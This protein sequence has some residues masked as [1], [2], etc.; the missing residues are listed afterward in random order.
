MSTDI[1]VIAL[2]LRPFNKRSVTTGAGN[3][4]GTT[5]VDVT[6]VE[7]DNFWTDCWVLLRTGTYAGQLRRVTG[8]VQ[9]TNTITLD[10]GVGGQIVPGVQYVMLTHI[11]VQ[12]SGVHTN[13]RRYEKDNGFRSPVVARAGGV[14]TPLWTIVTVPPRTAGQI[15]TMYTLTIENATG[16]AVTGWLEIAGVAITVPYH[17]A[18]NDSVVIDFVAGFDLG[19]N[20]INCNASVNGVNFQIVGT[21]V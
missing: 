5:L 20:D 9:A 12:D 13:P 14:A 8:F 19:D 18:D 4:G 15:S 6:L 2:Q 17:V 11:P 10:H 21:E 3:V 1:N 7:P 16:A